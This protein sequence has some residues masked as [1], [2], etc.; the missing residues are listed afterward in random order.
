MGTASFKGAFA[1][2]GHSRSLRHLRAALADAVR[3]HGVDE[4]DAAA[5]RLSAPR[6]LTQEIARAVF[7][8]AGPDGEAQFAGIRY[9][10]R[11]GDEL[12]NWALLERP[13]VAPSAPE[14]NSI[15]P[16]DPDLRRALAHLDLRL[17]SPATP[18]PPET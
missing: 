4:L 15:A 14:V 18:S 7:E 1:D 12:A 8:C 5:I 16:E 17:G 3:R 13:G 9:G 6:R 10:S 11:L 2:I